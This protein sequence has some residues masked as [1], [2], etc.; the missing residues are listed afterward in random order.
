MQLDSSPIPQDTDRVARLAAIA[1][2]IGSAILDAERLLTAERA[3]F[4]RTIAPEIRR[5]AA[6]TEEL[7]SRLDPIGEVEIVVTCRHCRHEQ[8]T[9]IDWS[10]PCPACGGER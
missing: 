5:L 10:A 2:R 7:A 3:D 4:L 8:P 1:A 6:E 9:P